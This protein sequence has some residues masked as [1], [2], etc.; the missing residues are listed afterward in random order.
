M[1]IRSWRTSAEAD[2][3]DNKAN[4]VLYTFNILTVLLIIAFL[5]TL[6]NEMLRTIWWYLTLIPPLIAILLRYKYNNHDHIFR[7]WG[8]SLLVIITFLASK[9]GYIPHYSSY[10]LPCA[11]LIIPGIILLMKSDDLDFSNSFMLAVIFSTFYAVSAVNVLNTKL[12]NKAPAKGY[13][14][15]F[16]KKKVKQKMNYVYYFNVSAW[17]PEKKEYEI[18]VDDKIGKD[19][20]I[21]DTLIFN[22]Y[23][24]ALGIEYYTIEGYK[25]S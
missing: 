12:D 11:V 22:H 2:R 18:K 16:S 8:A 6:K 15:I 20:N 1:K 25:R 19:I 5:G 10:L 24:G 7:T 23:Q 9:P 4:R 17:G 14:R 13:A 3:D 21:N